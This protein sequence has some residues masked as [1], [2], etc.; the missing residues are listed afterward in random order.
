MAEES[1]LDLVL[2]AETG[3]DG[4]PVVKI[5]DFGKALYEKKKKLLKLKSIK[6]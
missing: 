3:K 4:V 1:G 5:M 6:K 2:I